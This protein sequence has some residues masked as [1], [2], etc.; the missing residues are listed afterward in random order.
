MTLAKEAEAFSIGGLVRKFAVPVTRKQLD[1]LL[2][3]SPYALHLPFSYLPRHSF[4]GIVLPPH[5][6]LAGSH[7]AS[8]SWK[9]AT[10]KQSDVSSCCF[11][12]SDLT[13]ACFSQSNL[14]G[15]DWNGCRVSEARFDGASLKGFDVQKVSDKDLTGATFSNAAN[16]ASLQNWQGVRLGRTDFSGVPFRKNNFTL[17]FGRSMQKC[18]FINCDLSGCDF[19]GVDMAGVDFSGANLTGANLCGVNFSGARLVRTKLN[20]CK[21]T[22]CDFSGADLT[23]ATLIGSDLSRAILSGTNLSQTRWER[24][25]QVELQCTTCTWG[26]GASFSSLALTDAIT[27]SLNPLQG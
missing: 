8:S 5:S 18:K 14:D 16:F 4:D 27:A 9:A 19:S 10:V 17:A 11:A 24:T 2:A 3:R 12:S 7:F 21:L 25:T 6:K 26:D 1:H 22:G 15:V 20:K 23:G 13:G